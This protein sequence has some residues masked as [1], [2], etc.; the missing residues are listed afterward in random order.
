[1]PTYEYRCTNCD[2]HLEVVQSFTEEPLTKCPNCGGQLRK[3]FSPVGIVFK[4]SG[5]YKTDSRGGGKGGAHKTKEKEKETT[6]ASSSSSSSSSSDTS[7]SSSSSS[8]DSKK[9]S[10]I[11]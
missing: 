1:M 3:V 6:S 5:F 4:G 11:A 9:D 8:S 7:S 2:E 10:K